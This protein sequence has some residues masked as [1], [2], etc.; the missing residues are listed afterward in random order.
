MAALRML[1]RCA[2]SSSRCLVQSKPLTSQL[3]LSAAFS[4][5]TENKVAVP[6]RKI[7]PNEKFFDKNERMQRPMSPHVTIY[8]FPLPALTS[9]TN[10][11][12]GGAMAGVVIAAG[13]GALVSPEPISV[14]VD[15]VRDMH[16]PLW[17]TIPFKTAL[18]F[19]VAYHTING[20]RHLVYDMGIG[21]KLTETYTSGYIVIALSLAATAGLVYLSC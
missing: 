13:C 21:Y 8:A 19:P 16:L 18:C 20:V 5:S 6:D 12:T 14:Y 17:A 1:M 3:R 4:T 10:R 11:V 7:R 15:M 2:P 9:I